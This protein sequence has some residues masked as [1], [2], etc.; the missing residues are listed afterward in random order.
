MFKCEIIEKEW[1]VRWI[2]KGDTERQAAL[3]N[4]MIKKGKR[5]LMKSNY[6]LRVSSVVKS[7]M[8]LLDV[9]CGT[10]H[11]IENLAVHDKNTIFVSLD[12]SPAMLKIAKLNTMKLPNIMLVEGD[13]LKLPF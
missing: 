13:G 1:S 6:V 9:D 12:V 8:K 5:S 2:V 7:R 10:A 4:E 3:R 11:I